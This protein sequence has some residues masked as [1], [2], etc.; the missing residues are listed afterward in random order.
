MSFVW[1]KGISDVAGGLANQFL[2]IANIGANGAVASVTEKSTT[3]IYLMG[4]LDNTTIAG[5]VAEFTVLQVEFFDTSLNV[6]DNEANNQDVKFRLTGS[7]NP[8]IYG[9]RLAKGVLLWL[10]K[11]D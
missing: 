8:I 5:E 4:Y 6:K 1:I 9:P 11:N 7:A 2:R 3:P 10:K